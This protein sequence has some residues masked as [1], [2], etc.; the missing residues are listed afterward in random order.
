[1]G[2]LLHWDI[3]ALRTCRS[4]GLAFPWCI[5][6]SIFCS[7]LAA[8]AVLKCTLLLCDVLVWYLLVL[9]LVRSV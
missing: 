5:S 8:A 6:I 9:L 1:M 3:T 4:D 2:I 7:P